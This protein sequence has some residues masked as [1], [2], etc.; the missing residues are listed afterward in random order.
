MLT[1]TLAV[2]SVAAIVG[3]FS[4]GSTSAP[5]NAAAMFTAPASISTSEKNIQLA[6][7]VVKKKKVVKNKKN[8]N[9]VVRTTT[10]HYDANRHGHRY[11]HRTGAYAYYYNGYYYEQPWWTI[12]VPGVNLCIGC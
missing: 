12:A 1:R 2:A 6:D 4:L 11:R 8:G 5:T 3:A 9:K 7:Y 10:W